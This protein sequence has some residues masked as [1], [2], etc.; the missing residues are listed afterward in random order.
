MVALRAPVAGF[1]TG[2]R[3]STLTNFFGSCINAVLFGQVA[4]L[5]TNR[6]SVFN[7]YAAIVAR[8]VGRGM[9]HRKLL[10]M[11]VGDDRY[12]QEMEAVDRNMRVLQLPNDVQVGSGRRDPA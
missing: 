7:R 9:L 8:G 10:R 1:A 4:E 11:V 2:H 5:L 12:R 6:D 3:F